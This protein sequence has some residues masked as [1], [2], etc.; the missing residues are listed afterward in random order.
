MER[1]LIVEVGVP[2]EAPVAGAGDIA[3]GV[4]PAGR[5]VTLLHAGHPDE[6]VAVSAHLQDWAAARGL[7][8]DSRP[9]AEGDLWGCRLETFLTDP[10][11]VTDPAQWQTELAYK[12]AD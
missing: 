11:E 9:S 4:L 6:L 2:V 10:R 3:A 1:E 5:F 12:L 7:E 8:F